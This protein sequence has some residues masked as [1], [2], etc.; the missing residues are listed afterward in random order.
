MQITRGIFQAFAMA[1]LSAI[2]YIWF[3]IEETQRTL[4]I[5]FLVSLLVLLSVEYVREGFSQK[6]SKAS[7]DTKQDEVNAKQ[8]FF[9]F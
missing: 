6:K 9:F 2:V 5:V 3:F 1:I 4:P 7:H 8:Y